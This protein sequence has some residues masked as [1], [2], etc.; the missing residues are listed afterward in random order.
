MS[1]RP[2]FKYS[3]SLATPP[4]RSNKEQTRTKRHTTK[5]TQPRSPDLTI[6]KVDP[7][8]HVLFS[9]SCP[10]PSRFGRLAGALLAGAELFLQKNCSL[11][12]PTLPPTRPRKNHL[13]QMGN[14]WVTSWRTPVSGC[15]SSAFVWGSWVCMKW[16]RSDGCPCQLLTWML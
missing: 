5:W 12:P 11:S 4:H 9:S 15:W 1:K 7:H 6:K 3:P 16:E 13:K 14:Y 2:R 8:I 10:G